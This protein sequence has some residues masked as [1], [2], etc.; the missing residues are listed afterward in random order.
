MFMKTDRP[1]RPVGS[2]KSSVVQR[3]PHAC[4][5][6][7]A[8]VEFFEEQRWG[9]EPSCPHC[10]TL[11]ECYQMRDR[12]TGERNARYLWRCRAC[13]KQYTVRVGSILEDSAIPFRIWALAFWLAC[14]SKKGVSALQVKRLTGLSYKSAL[15]MMHRIRYAMS[16]TP[17]SATPLTGTV[18]VDETYVGG[19]PRNPDR[20]NIGRKDNK[21]CVV[22]MVERGGELRPVHVTPE[23]DGGVRG[24]LL[25]HVD[26]SARII[27]DESYLYRKV[28]KRFKGGHESVM[29]S[30]REYARGDVHTNTIE[31]FF[32]LLKRGVYGT[33]HSISKKHLHRYLSEFQ[34]R[35]NTRKAD[36]GARTVLA[37]RKAQWKRLTYK[38]QVGH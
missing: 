10:G 2:D 17:T 29:H 16:D 34:F 27:T 6:E 35:Y 4:R 14:S 21:A 28:G 12:K 1:Q 38:D 15:F 25:R 37:I 8:A 20:R 13:S 18:E 31:G 22:G 9:S 5:D 26:Q 24:A 32:S 30:L 23:A 19:K 33:F 11:G 7:R 36:D 3:L